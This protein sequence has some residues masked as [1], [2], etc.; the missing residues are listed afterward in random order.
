MLLMCWGAKLL[1]PGE[2]EGALG[3]NVYIYVFY[4]VRCAAILGVAGSTEC[5]EQGIFEGL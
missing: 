3:R 1:P 2:D 5:V 4:V